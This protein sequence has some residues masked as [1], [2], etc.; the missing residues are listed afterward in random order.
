MKD[1]KKKVDKT[2][3]DLM[4]QN[5]TLKDELKKRIENTDI[6]TFND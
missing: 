1:E 4:I 3:I 5:K 6:S 2:F